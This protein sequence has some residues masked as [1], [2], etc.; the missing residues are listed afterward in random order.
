MDQEVDGEMLG[1][2]EMR[3]TQRVK[4]AAVADAVVVERNARVS[5]VI[6][7]IESRG[8]CAVVVDAERRPIG[9]VSEGDVNYARSKGL[10]EA[11]IWTVMS[12]DPLTAREDW[13]LSEARRIMEEAGINCMPVVD[14]RGRLVGVL[15]AP[16][17]VAPAPITA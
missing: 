11:P 1:M 4:D 17:A 8:R 10:E 12:E 6:E 16:R 14:S 13:S 2:F 9:V 15:M 5:D 3:R 7:M